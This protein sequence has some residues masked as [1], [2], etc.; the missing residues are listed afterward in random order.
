MTGHQTHAGSVALISIIIPCFNQSHFLRAAIESVVAQTYEPKEVIVIDD[1]STDGTADVAACYSVKCIRQKNLGLAAARNRGL[2]ETSGEFVVFLDAD[3]FLLPDALAAGVSSLRA[4]PE[5][6][7]VFGGYRHVAFDGSPL[8]RELPPEDTGSYLDLLHYNQV[9]CV[10]AVM[11]RRRNLDAVGAFDRRFNPAEDYELY[12]RIARRYPIRRHAQTVAT[13][14]RYATSMSGNHG[15]MLRAILRV[16][17]AQRSQLRSPEEH[18]AWIEGMEGNREYYR[19]LIRAQVRGDDRETT[20]MSRALHAR[21]TLL[22]WDPKSF[23]KALAPRLYIGVFRWRDAIRN[24]LIR[25]LSSSGASRGTI[26]ASPNPIRVG[27]AHWNGPGSTAIE[28]QAHGTPAIQ[29]RVDR[30]DGPLF[31]STSPEGREDTGE[32]VTDGTR[33]YLQDV[34]DDRS[35]SGRTLAVVTVTVVP[36][37]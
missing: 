26:R 6:A 20:S 24:R 12:L 9:G 32:W 17:R 19:A 16:F 14:R 27:T 10:A 3:D 7:F 2:R 4:H 8:P 31:S 18:R 13:Y 34:A 1:G 5:C 28:W 33:F 15:R 37:G 22:R 21:A 35:A 25:W 36:S 11:Y 23:F 29:V 30:P